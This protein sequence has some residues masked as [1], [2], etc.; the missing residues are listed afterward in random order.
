MKAVLKFIKKEPILILAVILAII[1]CFFVPPSKEYI[2]YINFKTLTSIFSLMIIVK[3]LSK[4]NT[5]RII[6]TKILP[7]TKSSRGLITVLV[8]IPTILALF[9]TNDVAVLTFVPFALIV[10][11]MC[12]MQ[13]LALKTVVLISIGC[14]LGGLISP[15]GNSQ[16]LY[17]FSYYDLP[18]TFLMQ[19]AYICF[20]FGIIFLFACCML[21]K[22]Q[23]VTTFDNKKREVKKTKLAVYLVLLALAVSAVVLKIDYYYLITFGIVAVTML[24]VD[25]SL[26]K[27]LNYS[28]LVTFTAFFIFSGNVKNIESVSILLSKIINGNEFFLLIGLTQFISNTPAVII[29]S[30]FSNNVLPVLLGANIAKNG[31]ILASLTGVVV[32]RLYTS[33]DNRPL[34]FLGMFMSYGL[35]FLAIMT[36]VGYLNILLMT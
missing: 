35:I 3:G 10:L 25:R 12:D 21:T 32:M 7:F 28:I 15:M 16:N 24:V 8:F 29:I 2:S 17:L 13:H 31:T 36:G 6:A 33:F 22:K 27:S 30:Q 34:R 18:S 1:S 23:P 9:I 11:N 19:N 14:N 4:I 5:F 20:I 26:F